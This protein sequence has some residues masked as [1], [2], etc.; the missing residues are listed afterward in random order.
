MKDELNLFGE[1]EGAGEPTSSRQAETPSEREGSRQGKRSAA[2]PLAARMRPRTVAEIR[3]QDH[4]LAE[5]TSLRAALEGGELSSMILWGPPGSGKTTVA[6][7]L[8]QRGDATFVSLSAVTEGVTRIREVVKQART[9][10]DATGRRTILF[11]DEIHRFNRAQQDAF[12]PHVEEG[13]VVLVGATTENPSFEINRPLL[14]R[15]PVYLL[16]PL[17]AREIEE[18][19]VEALEDEERGVGGMALEADPEALSALA[20]WADGDARRALNA[21]EAAASLAGPGGGLGVDEVREGLQLRFAHY[22]KGREEGYNLISAFHKSI[23]GG[24]PDGA[25]YW[26]A[27]MLDGGEDPGY[28]ARRMFRMASEDVGMADPEALR[29]VA[30]GWEAYQ[31]AGSP[32]GDLALAQMAVY[33][34]SATKSNRLY[35]AWRQVLEAVREHPGA[36]VPLHLRN[37]PTE[38][39]EEIGYGKGY[40]YD[41]DEPKGIAA[42]EYLPESLRGSRF[43]D[44]GESGFEAVLGERLARWR[45]L[46]SGGAGALED[47]EG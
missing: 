18:I 24:D 19:L 7:L 22:D 41:P 23:R 8:A 5:G 34:A 33:L 45:S 10:L 44:P 31:A 39:L 42:Q 14:S 17:D 21:L 16:K 26:L 1:S 28:L 32:E 3:G 25:L 29:T 37:A 43:Y 6:R 11:C 36:P 47:P 4:L 12:L 38:L 30:A 9:R 2:Q 27:R 20:R 46:R 15:A 35:R 13:T 40:R